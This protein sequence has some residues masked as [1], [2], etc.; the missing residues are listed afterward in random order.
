MLGKLKMDRKSN[1]THRCTDL[2]KAKNYRLIVATNQSY[3]N[4]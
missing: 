4:K 1:M 3:M 2:R